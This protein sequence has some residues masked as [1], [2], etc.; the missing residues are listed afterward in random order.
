MKA[1]K[2]IT[3]GEWSAGIGKYAGNCIVET[4]D[5]IITNLF[6]HDAEDDA[7]ARM[8]AASKKLAGIL[9]KI[10][11]DARHMDLYDCAV[12]EDLI[13]EA[14]TALIEAGYTHEP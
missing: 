1:P 5:N 10:E 11:K 13:R 8:M 9:N 3:D 14:R 4:E 7:N 12:S 2:D 6:G